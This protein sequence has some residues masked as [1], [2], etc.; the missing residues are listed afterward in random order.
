MRF[1]A[2]S[3]A[4]AIAWAVFVLLILA[5]MALTNRLG[6]MGLLLLGGATCLVCVT[7]ELDRNAP[8]WGV[9]VFRA[10]LTKPSSPEQRAA[11]LDEGRLFVSPLRFYRWCG[12]FLML[13]GEVG[14]AAQ[15]WALNRNLLP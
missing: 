13:V 1:S 4:N 15:H 6:F 10:R 3:A 9:E 12:L 5:A 8:T 2:S 7:A 14:F 11:M